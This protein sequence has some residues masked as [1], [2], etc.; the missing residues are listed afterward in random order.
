MDPRYRLQRRHPGEGLARPHAT[1]VRVL[2]RDR[3]LR[4]P[5]ATLGEDFEGR[6]GKVRLTWRT[7]DPAPNAPLLKRL[8]RYPY[9]Q[10]IQR[11][12]RVT[13]LEGPN[14]PQKS[15]DSFASG[16]REARAWRVRVAFAN[17]L[18]AEQPP[19]VERRERPSVE[20]WLGRR[21]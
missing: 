8:V 4:A 2:E 10:E 6:T 17:P 13:L 7:A 16:V 12:R 15:V 1:S 9:R 20:E 14:R 5:R 18:R 19:R 11:G 3:P 21:D